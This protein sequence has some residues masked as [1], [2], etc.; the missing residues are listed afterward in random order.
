MSFKNKTGE[1]LKNLLESKGTAGALQVIEKALKEKKISPSDFS[2]KEIWEACTNGASVHEA[3]SYKSF[4]KITGA[5]INSQLI[6]AYDHVPTIGDKITTTLKSVHKNETIAGISAVE[7]PDK[8]AEQERYKDSSITEKY[9]TA[10]S[11]KYGRM[12]S[13]TEEMIYF[14]QTD[15]VLIRANDIGEE[16]AQYKE[17]LIVEGV[18]DVNSDVWQPSGVATAIY[19]ST[20]KNT[21]SA[22]FGESGLETARKTIQMMQN[23]AGDQASS[24]DSE[25][26]Y[27]FID[28]ANMILLVPSDLEVEAWQME[29][30]ALTPESAENAK[31]FFKGRFTT[32]TSPYISKR[33]TTNWFMGNFK[34]DFRWIEVWPLQTFTQPAGHEDEFMADIKTR[35]KVRFYGTV[36]A[37]D[38]KHS[39]KFT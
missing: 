23:D 6:A 30:S 20:N 9:V 18:L 31:N 14:D 4:P 2:L 7:G 39:Y 25:K 3:V 5:L 26:D 29:N 36:A 37:V 10:M 34:K 15:Q 21:A 27:I 38:F 11:E 13:I 12:I 33:S 17:K 32:L 8:V 35:L 1:A 28:D 22:T 16:T 24:T 19:S